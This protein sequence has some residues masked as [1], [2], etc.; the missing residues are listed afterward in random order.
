MVTIEKI[1]AVA[2]DRLAS[3]GCRQKLLDAIAERNNHEF[4]GYYYRDGTYEHLLAIYNAKCAFCESNSLAAAALQV[5]HYR[6]KDRLRNPDTHLGY[7]WLAYEWSNLLLCCSKCNRN[8]WNHFP[9]ENEGA[10]IVSPQ[11]DQDGF[12]THEYLWLN[13]NILSGERAMLLNPEV[14]TVEDHIFFKPDGRV[15]HLTDRGEVTIGLCDLNREDLILARRKIVDKYYNQF[16]RVFAGYRNGNLDW[17]GLNFSL[18][19][20]FLEVLQEMGFNCNYSRLGWFMVHHFEVFFTRKLPAEEA[21]VLRNR[22]NFF[23]LN[24]FS[25][26][27]AV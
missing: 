19:S 3:A 27:T 4:S 12:P 23:L 7:Y 18:E 8:K 1:F 20:I 13:S 17:Q 16:V 14:D 26:E 22:Y 9:L 2:P 25:L 11:L 15:G 24:N 5:D 21:L 10:R 6:P